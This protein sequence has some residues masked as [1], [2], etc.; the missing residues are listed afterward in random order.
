MLHT[1]TLLYNGTVLVTGNW[2]IGQGST[3]CEVYVP[4]KFNGEGSWKPN[5]PMNYKRGCHTATM[6]QDGR[7]LVVGGEINGSQS[8][9]PTCEI[10]NAFYFQTKVEREIPNHIYLA[11]NY[12]NPFGEASTSRTGTTVIEFSIPTQSIVTIDVFNILGERICR[13]ANQE[14]SEGTHSTSWDGMNNQNIPLPAG[15]YF[16]RLMHEENVLTKRMVLMR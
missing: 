14:F 16:Y 4:D 15:V 13:L 2:A 6:L 8:A 5:E 9:T 10:S 12:P 1:A 11:Q 3:S 7:V